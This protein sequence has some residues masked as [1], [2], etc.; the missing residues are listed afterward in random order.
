MNSE[1]AYCM[2]LTSIHLHFKRFVSRHE[3]CTNQQL[4][5]KLKVKVKKGNLS[6]QNFN[7]VNK[8]NMKFHFLPDFQ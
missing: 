8:L 2:G 7:E 1:M 6:K 4:K 3:D 5:C